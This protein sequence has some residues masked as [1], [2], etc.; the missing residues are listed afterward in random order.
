MSWS[1]DNPDKTYDD[2]LG[3]MRGLIQRWG[4]AVQAVEGDRLHVRHAEAPQIGEV[5]AL[6]T[7]PVVVGSRSSVCRALR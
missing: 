4:F 6:R 1:C 3:H 2:Y 5:M 7:A